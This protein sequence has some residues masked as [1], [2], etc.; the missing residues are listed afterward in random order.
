MFLSSIRLDESELL[1]PMFTV[2]PVRAS[3]TYIDSFLCDP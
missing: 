1:L 2:L 3:K